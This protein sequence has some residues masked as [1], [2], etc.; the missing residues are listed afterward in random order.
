MFGTFVCVRHAFRYV[1]QSQNNRVVISS[2]VISSAVTHFKALGVEQGRLIGDVL[3]EL[4]QIGR[5]ALGR[6]REAPRE[7]SM[8]DIVSPRQHNRNVSL[9]LRSVQ[10]TFE[11]V[12]CQHHPVDPSRTTWTV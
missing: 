4:L 11:P 5:A 10:D 9:S 1:K 6:P 8:Y 2:A 3:L 7:R 12:R